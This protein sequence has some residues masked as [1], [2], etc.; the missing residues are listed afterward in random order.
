[1]LTIHILGA[2]FD[3]RQ[4][5]GECKPKNYEIVQTY[6]YSVVKRRIIDLYHCNLVD[7]SHCRSKA[8]PKI[9]SRWNV[10][11]LSSSQTLNNFRDV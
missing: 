1:M 7:Q 9:V 5:P 10:D 4:I 3:A 11:V 6:T 8:V 2:A